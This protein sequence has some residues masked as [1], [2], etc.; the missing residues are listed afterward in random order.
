MT[1]IAIKERPILFSGPMV[2]AILEGRKTQTRRVVKVPAWAEPATIE[3]GDDGRASAIAKSSGCMA[4]FVC[5]YGS[6]GCF[7]VPLCTWSAEPKYDKTKPSHLPKSARIWTAWDGDKPKW[8]GKNRPG[9]FMP[10]RLRGLLPRF[11][12]A[13]V[14]VERLYSITEADALAEGFDPNTCEQ[15][16][17]LAAGKTPDYQ[18][19]HW[20]EHDET[21]EGDMTDN[22]SDY[23]RGCAL[24]RQKKLGKE[25]RLLSDCGCASESDGPAYCAICGTA[26]LMS[27]TEYGVER[28]LRIED[29]PAGKEPQHF[30]CTGVDARIAAMIAGRIGNLDEK[31]Y[32]RLAQI[33]FASAWDVINGKKYPWTMNPRVWVVEFKVA[34]SEA[35]GTQP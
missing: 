2:R 9:R 26:L 28:E 22:G 10:K 8:A 18:S 7:L 12:I 30:P 15:F 31:H 32:G 5:P 25:W 17:T 11:P 13:G 14:R 19:L 23:C 16:L 21:G 4:D 24:K 20:L 3:E 35:K 27:L 33:G 6:P 1:A 29:D 34:P